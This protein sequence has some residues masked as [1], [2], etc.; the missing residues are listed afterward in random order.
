MEFVR[1]HSALLILGAVIAFGSFNLGVHSGERKASTPI[2]NINNGV[3][4]EVA[5]VDF[6][7][8][9]K[10]WNLINEKY[11]PASTTAKVATQDDKIW[12]AIQGLTS[13]LGDP[14]TVFFPP[15]EAELFEADIRGDF[16]GLGMEIV[17]QEGAITVVAPLKSSPAE[18]AGLLAGDR[19]IKIDDKNNVA[20]HAGISRGRCQS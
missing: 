1:K 12:G 19:I 2:N 9:W 4:G 5:N 3:E 13:S 14:Y 6:S 8:F 10:A 7:P 15:V 16:E 11:V 17:A 18:K 20:I